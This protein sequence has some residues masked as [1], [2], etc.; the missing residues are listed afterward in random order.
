VI[1]H[2]SVGVNTITVSGINVPA[3]SLVV[4]GAGYGSEGSG[5]SF[6]NGGWTTPLSERTDEPNPISAILATA[7]GIES[8][9]QTTK[10]YIAIS[11]VTY[12]RGTG[13]VSVWPSASG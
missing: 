3:G 12:N 9:A 5:N 1:E 13:I 2:T 4:M 8:V 10:T 6:N 11:S 7:S